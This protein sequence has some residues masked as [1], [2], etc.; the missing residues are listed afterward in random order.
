[1][2]GLNSSIIKNLSLL[3][4]SLDE[5]HAIAA[6]LDRETARI[7]QLIAKKERQIE[8]LQ[9][10]RSALISHAVTKGLNPKAKMKDSGIKW[11]GEMPEHWEVLRFKYLLTE[12][13]KYGANEVA[14]LDDPA[15]PRYVRITDVNDDG[16][17]RDDTFK[18]LPEEIA[19]PYLL[20]EGDLLFAR[21]GATVGKTFYY[22]ASWGRAAYA[23]Y[24]IRARIDKNKMLSKFAAYFAR[25][26]NYWNWLSSSFI[27][28]TIQNVSA[29]KYAGLVLGV[30]PLEEQMAIAN[31]IDKEASMIDALTLKLM[32]SIAKLR[33]YRTP[34]ISA[35]VTCQI[36]V[37]VECA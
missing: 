22:Q 24:L 1:M 11:L 17:L 5:Q 10:K 35:A 21:S 26:S 7:D 16:T 6:F 15:L 28:A 23:D 8:L 18:S 36:N 25:S 37:R 9:E 32:D 30:P 3:L 33:E 14:E 27:K 19:K 13:L 12:P 20:T 4:P 34:L 29:E 2:E 31:Y